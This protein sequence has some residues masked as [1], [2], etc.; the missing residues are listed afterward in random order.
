MNKIYIVGMGPGSEDAL[1][2]QAK[3][4][5]TIS[6]CIVGYNVYLDLL[7]DELKKKELISTPM[8]Q[9]VRRCEIVYEEALKGKT[10]SIICSGDAGVY[11]MASLMYE[12][13]E[14]YPNTTLEVIPGIT[15]ALSGAAVL[16]APVNHDFCIISLSDLLTP[17]E[18]I[19]K[20]IRAAADGDFAIVLYNPS[21]HKRKDYLKRACE[22]LLETIENDRPCGYVKNIGRDG[23]ESGVMTLSELRDFETDMFTTVFI[24]NSESRI[25]D[26]AL[27]TGRGYKI[28]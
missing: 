11:G 15:A 7:P 26:G 19:E 21:S 28:E 27:V 4:A 22:I 1:T 2:P 25:I 13:K 24:G 10:V 23:Q 8:K 3:N 14:R 12:L 16:G 5:L 18:K 17:W 9:E 20:R 6:D